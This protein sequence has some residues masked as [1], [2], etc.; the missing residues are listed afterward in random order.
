MVK[1]FFPGY[2]H[3]DTAHFQLQDRAIHYRSK[4]WLGWQTLGNKAEVSARLLH[5][6]LNNLADDQGVEVVAHSL[7]CLIAVWAITLLPADKRKQIT[8]LT[9]VAPTGFCNRRRFLTFWFLFILVGWR[10]HL[11]ALLGLLFPKHGALVPPSVAT[12][13]YGHRHETGEIVHDSSVAFLQLVL[14]LY[15]NA[16]AR[17]LAQGFDRDKITMVGGTHDACVNAQWVHD[18]AATAETSYHEL[19]VAHCG[20]PTTFPY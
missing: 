12:R 6:I 19:P 1:I 20:H 3:D 13:L 14:G 17:L 2:A 18:E 4:S 16:L 9:L 8:Q 7:G 11:A 15:P 10:G 5:G